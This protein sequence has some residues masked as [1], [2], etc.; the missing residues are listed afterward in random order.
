VG[1]H[2]IGERAGAAVLLW[3]SE[4]EEPDPDPVGKVA[5]RIVVGRF[6]KRVDEFGHA[7]VEQPAK[8]VA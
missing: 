4:P 8:R 1:C 2:E 3:Q 5:G 7:A 6:R